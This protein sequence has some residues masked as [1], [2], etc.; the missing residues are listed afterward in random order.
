MLKSRDLFVVDNAVP[1][2]CDVIVGVATG[3][4]G[5]YQDN[6]QDRESIT[7]IDVSDTRFV[8]TIRHIPEIAIMTRPIC[9]SRRA[10]GSP[11]TKKKMRETSTQEPPTATVT[12]LG[13]DHFLDIPKTSANAVTTSHGIVASLIM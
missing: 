4:D 6:T 9:V 13:P 12:A 11:I 2:G 1:I 7:G 5:K 10:R 3:H 8:G